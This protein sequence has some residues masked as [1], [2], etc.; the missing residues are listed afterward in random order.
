MRD[1][2]IGV[3]RGDKEGLAK[4]MPAETQQTVPEPISLAECQALVDRIAGSVELR[5]AARLRSFL[6]Y[7]CEQSLKHGSSA[8]HEQEIGSAVFGRPAAYDTG[9]DNIVRVNATELRKRLEHYFTEEGV[10]EEILL[11]IQRGSYTPVFRR[12]LLPTSAS[13]TTAPSRN[14]PAQVDTVLT[15]WDASSRGTVE[16]PQPAAETMAR[17][18]P[19]GESSASPDI[20]ATA[21]QRPR[22]PLWQSL[23]LALLLACAWLGWQVHLLTERVEPWRREP[24]LRAFWQEFFQSGSNTDLVLAD[25]SFALAEDML[26]RPISL[27]DYLNYNY[28]HFAD[29]PN[30]SEAQ[31]RDLAMVLERNNGSIA[32]FRVGQQILALNSSDPQQPALKF[33]REYTPGAA[34]RNSLIL[35]GSQQSNPWVG[36]FAGRLNFDPE[37]DSAQRLPYIVNRSPQPGEAAMYPAPKNNDPAGISYAVIAFIPN[38][39]GKG[40]TLIIAGCDSQATGAAGDFITSEDAL[41]TLEQKF[42]K[43]RIPYFEV[44]LRT[45]QLSGT[46]L[47]GEVIAYRIYR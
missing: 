36:L 27:T 41:A 26:Q 22:F 12:R 3:R 16:T 4:I 28:K 21:S 31:R 18:A 37:Y 47:R 23:S 29:A 32:D 19:A 10:S 5:R 20:R 34:K 44:L 46:P 14:D 8:I 15:V 1:V 13:A 35:I 6:L 45:S 30:L 11:E 40:R 42:P 43:G 33:A 17:T 38:V 9:I 25:T 39:S 24:A 2:R 7:V